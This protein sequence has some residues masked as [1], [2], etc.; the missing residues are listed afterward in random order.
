MVLF[1]WEWKLILKIKNHTLSNEQLDWLNEILASTKQP[2]LIFTHCAVDDHDINGNFFYETFDAKQRK[3]FFLKNQEHIQ[4]II[5]KCSFVKA[6]FQAHLHYFHSKIDDGV[7]YIT[8]PAMADNICGPDMI[9]N[10][11]EIYTLLTIEN[12]RLSVKAF[13]REYCFAGTEII[14]SGELRKPHHSH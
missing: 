10:I 6:V 3:G 4:T 9:D 7:S 12:P 13:S 2:T 8:C 11:P 5:S 1:G 14:L